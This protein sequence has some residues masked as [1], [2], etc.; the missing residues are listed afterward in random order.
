MS[1]AMILSQNHR[2]KFGFK[3]NGN[4]LVLGQVGTGKTR[5]HI[6]PNIMEQDEISMIIADTKGELR[7]KTESL[8]RKKGYV[9]KSINFDNP[10]TSKDFFNPFTYIR[11]PEDIL[12]IANIIV[13]TQQEH[14]HVD[15]YWNNAA[16]LLLQACIAY[17]HTQARPAE[18]TLT[19]L[20]KMVCAFSVHEE[21][22]SFKCPLEI[23]F[24]DLK[25]KDANCFVV[26]Q[27][28]AFGAIK[29][30]AKTASTICSVALSAFASLLTPNIE[31][32]TSN[33]T[34]DFNSIGHKKTALFVSV[35]DVD[36]SKDRLVSLFYSLLLNTLRNEADQQPEKGLP[37]HV[38]L[39]LDDMATNICIPSF[40]TYISALRSREISFSVVLQSEEQLKALYGWNASTIIANCGYYIFLGSNDLG[41]CQKIARRLNVPLDKV[42]YK[43]RD[44]VFVLNNFERPIVDKVYDLTSHPEYSRLENEQRKPKAKTK[45]L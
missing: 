31:Q 6:L 13:S 37:I 14:S 15:P 45:E 12:M 27:W 44:Q 8:L 18:R 24:N 3:D 21:D 1:Y 11:C 10:A 7:A 23:I 34:L 39:F 38:H 5:S 32:L 29:G 20:Q 2:A 33:D 16:I 22:S 28:E 4:I 36:R 9:V 35:S 19:N 41:C 25:K 17:L 42:L 26:R 40:P 43:P 30:V